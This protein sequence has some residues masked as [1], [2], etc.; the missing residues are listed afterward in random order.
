MDSIGFI[1]FIA[2]AAFV[3]PV[4]IFSRF[5]KRTAARVLSYPVLL[6]IGIFVL[7]FAIH[8]G[9]FAGAAVATLSA[10]CGS[11]T[12]TILRRYYGY[13]AKQPVIIKGKTKKV[14]VF[15][16]GWAQKEA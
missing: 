4:F 10:L 14:K 2:L 9:S 5:E 11:V 3:G 13:Y 1:L 15:V 12:I 7:M 16:P 8:G 6:D